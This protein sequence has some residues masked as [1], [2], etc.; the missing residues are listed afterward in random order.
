MIVKCRQKCSVPPQ[1]RKV[2]ERFCFI[3]QVHFSSAR[4]S[5]MVLILYY[6]PLLDWRTFRMWTL[7]SYT[8]KMKCTFSTLGKT[9]LMLCS[10]QT[11]HTHNV[12]IMYPY[13][14]IM[15]PNPSKI[16]MIHPYTG[17]HIIQVVTT[18]LWV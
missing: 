4:G 16:H 2:S 8:S 18:H 6:T 7:L 11:M 3:S 15:N 10:L 17:I 14:F 12:H 1:W 5:K 13:K 9:V